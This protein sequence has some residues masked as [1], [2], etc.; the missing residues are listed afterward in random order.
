MLGL[1]IEEGKGELLT[2]N[3]VPSRSVDEGPAIRAALEELV[4]R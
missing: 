4:G 1:M 3:G 2:R